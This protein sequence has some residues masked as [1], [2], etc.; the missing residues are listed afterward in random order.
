MNRILFGLTSYE[1]EIL[2][3]EFLRYC[4]YFQI[5]RSASTIAPVSSRNSKKWNLPPHLAA[6]YPFS[7]QPARYFTRGALEREKKHNP[8]PF[9]FLLTESDE[10]PRAR[11]LPHNRRLLQT[12]SSG[13]GILRQTAQGYVYLDID[14][15]FILSLLP[16]LT[17]QGL[18]RPPYF[19]L[20]NSPEGAH[21]PVISTRE[22]YFQDIGTIQEINQEFSFEIEGFYSVKPNLWPE[23]DEV[24][25]FKVACLALEKMRRK[26]FLPSLPSGHPFAIVSAIRPIPAP[27]ASPS[28][29]ML[30]ISP[31]AYAA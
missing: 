29:P 3:Q 8:A 30:R 9:F 23:I 7:Y 2:N 5:S 16:Y 10:N 4:T 25:Y 31:A 13:K 18:S 17:A 15:Q 6:A 19:N 28:N 26:Y 12:L 14:N 21:I 11:P 20:F 1:K 27:A 22:S 24:W